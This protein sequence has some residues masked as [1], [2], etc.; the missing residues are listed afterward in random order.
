MGPGIESLLES[1]NE[2]DPLSPPPRTISIDALTPPARL[3][4]LDG[5][6]LAT[7]AAASIAGFGPFCL[8]AAGIPPVPPPPM[9]GAPVFA[10]CARS[11]PPPPTFSADLP[12]L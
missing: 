2:I 12:V 3:I 5:E 6:E 1:M 9:C 11:P 4:T 10:P 8:G 7:V